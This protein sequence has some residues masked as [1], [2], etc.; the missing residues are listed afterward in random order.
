[1]KKALVTGRALRRGPHCPRRRSRPRIT[2][3]RRS[4]SR[5]RSGAT[6]LS[7]STSS[8]RSSS[9]AVSATPT[10]SS[11]SGLERSG[12]RHGT[13]TITE[14]DRHGRAGPRPADRARRRA[15]SRL[16]AKW[17]YSRRERAADLPHPLPRR[18]RH[19]QLSRCRPS[20]IGR[21]SATAGTGRPGT[22]RRR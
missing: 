21:S 16:T 12:V 11:R 3:F 22:S 7:P 17:Y 20:S 19:H 8:G 13:S 5:S 1:M 14:L 10:S 2:I 15:A 4:G 6:A 18:R 9:T